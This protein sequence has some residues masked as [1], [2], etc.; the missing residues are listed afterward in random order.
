M[1]IEVLDNIPIPEKLKWD[2]GLHAKIFDRLNEYRLASERHVQQLHENW[3]RVDEH[4]RMYVNL[5]DNVVRGNRKVDTTKKENPFERSVTMPLEY[6]ML[7]TRT[8]QIS[9]ILSAAT[10]PIHLAGRGPEDYRGARM[11]EAVLTYD[12]EQSNWTLQNWQ[13]AFDTERYGSSCWYITWEEDYEDQPQ[14]G[15]IP[16]EFRDMLGP[17]AVGMVEPVTGDPRVVKQFNSVRTLDPYRLLPDPDVP[18]SENQKG[19]WFGHRE[20]MSWLWLND[21]RHAQKKGPYFNIEHIRDNRLPRD[22]TTG[23]EVDANFGDNQLRSYHHMTVHHLQCRIIPFEWEL[24]PS[25]ES[26]IWWFAIANKTT[27]IRAHKSPY[28]HKRYTYAV[29]QGDPDMHAPFTMGM[30]MQLEGMQRLTNWLVNSHIT[31]I[32]KAVNDEMIFDPELI[33]MGDLLSPGP[34]KMVRLTKQG[35][36]LLKQGVPISSMWTQFAIR[37]VTG[38][39]M[40]AAQ[41]LYA[42]AQR[43]SAAN[44]TA[45]GMPL[46]E[47]RT[48]GEVQT[49]SATAT[50]R[51]GT[52]AQLLDVMVVKEAAEQMVANNQRFRTMEQWIR[53]T[54]QLARQLKLGD[55]V[56]SLLMNQRDLE[57]NYDYVAR[58]STMAP[59][60][61]RD[62]AVWGAMMQVLASSPQLLQP[63]I[64][65][66]QIDPHSVFNQWLKAQGI[67]FFEEFYTDP[68]ERLSAQAP[69]GGPGGQVGVNIQPMEQIE[70]Q[71]E[72]GNLQAT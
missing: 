52:T 10:P 29:G 5:D 70:R 22:V 64:D 20:R 49:F 55:E 17:E 42:Q 41:M 23:R 25:R 53:V 65:G 69:P 66:K 50:Q 36:A 14:N 18:F 6:A 11:N 19:D 33:E 57:G 38:T 9:G 61:A 43:V 27:I 59:D 68:Q 16:P 48:L 47:K 60:P 32:R 4:M 26:E 34:A 8:T 63:D 12:A 54:G 28:P 37:D 56:K 51:I 45:M 31:N 58:T 21:H 7:M 1:P 40:E 71:V 30:G 3:N 67:N 46:P 72:A 13:L 15:M 35:S 39:H 24:S 44:D 2:S 62:A